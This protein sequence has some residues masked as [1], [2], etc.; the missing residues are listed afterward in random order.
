MSSLT[1]RQLGPP[2]II[3]NPRFKH[4][5]YKAKYVIKVD[6]DCE[7]YEEQLLKMIDANVAEAVAN[8]ESDGDVVYK[9]SAAITSNQL[10]DGIYT[11]FLSTNDFQSERLLTKFSKVQQSANTPS[12][13]GEPFTLEISTVRG[14]TG[15]TRPIGQSKINSDTGVYEIRNQD[16]ACFLLA[17]LIALTKHICLLH[18]DKARTAHRIAEQTTTAREKYIKPLTSWCEGILRKSKYTIHQIAPLVEG[19]FNAEHPEH[20][21]FQ[22]VVFASRNFNNEWLY[23]LEKSVHARTILPIYYNNDHYDTIWYPTKFFNSKYLCYTCHTTYNDKLQHR[24]SCTQKCTLC[25][26]TGIDYPCPFEDVHYCANCFTVFPNSDCYN[27]HL[28]RA[29]Y[30]FKTCQTCEKRYNTRE[31]HT[32]GSSYCYICHGHHPSSTSCFVQSLKPPNE[33]PTYK[34]FVYDFETTQNTGVNGGQKFKHIVN[35][36]AVK[37]MC[38]HCM[39]L[40]IYAIENA[41]PCCPCEL[42]Y[43]SVPED[44]NCLPLQEFW[45]YLRVNTPPGTTNVAVGHYAGRFDIHLLMEEIIAEN[46]RHDIKITSVGNKIYSMSINGGGAFGTIKFIDSYNHIPVSLE[47]MVETLGLTGVV[48]TKGMFPHMLNQEQF[49]NFDEEYLPPKTYYMDEFM[50]PQKRENFLKWYNENK[51]THFNFKQQLRDYC[52][53]DVMILVHALVMF[54]QQTREATGSPTD[55]ILYYTSTLASACMRDFRMTCMPPKSIALVPEHGL[56]RYVNQSKIALKMLR[57]LQHIN[58]YILEYRDSPGGEKRIEVIQDQK[59]HFYFVDG[60]V[61]RSPHKSLIIEI[62]GCY[63]HGCPQCFKNQ[64]TILPQG[65]RREEVFLNTMK[66]QKALEDAGYE[67]QYFWECDIKKMLQEN[68]DMRNFFNDELNNPGPLV[69]RDAFMGGR[70]GP[71][72]LYARSDT[73]TQITYT[74]IQSLYPYVLAK[75][76]MPFGIPERITGT[77]VVHWDS[78]GYVKDEGVYKVLIIP[79]TNLRFPVVP[80]KINEQLMFVL[81]IACAKRHCKTNFPVNID[82]E[83]TPEERQF[84]TTIASVELRLALEKGYIVKRF[85]EL[86]KCTMNMEIFKAYVMKNLK[87]KL[88]ASGPPP[89]CNTEQEKEEYCKEI[90]N[91]Y[92]FTIDKKNWVKNPGLRAIAK[93]RLNSLWGKFGQRTN[94]ARVEI[95]REPSDFHRIL[96]DFGNQI[97][98]LIVVNDTVAYLTIKRKEGYDELYDYSNILL[99]IFTTSCARVHLYKYMDQ[100]QGSS[101]LL[102]TD[103]DSCI[104]QHPR[105]HLPF[106]IDYFLGEMELE[107]GGEEILEYICGGAKQYGLALQNLRTKQVSFE[108]K[109]RGITL[110]HNVRKVLNYELLKKMVFS[111]NSTA[112]LTTSNRIL[113]FIVGGVY[114]VPMTKKYKPVFSK[115]F[116]SNDDLTILPYGYKP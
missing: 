87:L 42:K 61:D 46:D 73:K 21:P 93:L 83:H 69:L 25:G 66:R 75:Y 98:R 103:T 12:L 109:L 111:L 65:R 52:I 92:G 44:E 74:D 72:K 106:K 102:Y 1:F 59:Q 53:N 8:A 105:G 10:T 57:Y 19:Y 20:A 26:R 101:T 30:T 33:E 80:I 45:K 16:S 110:S 63:F 56:G 95:C 96:R 70:T 77:G 6:A 2:E 112:V 79:P 88:E 116:V 100:C 47:K 9:I 29:C 81:C 27:H 4:A 76:P 71:Y 108:L 67:V 36:A 78:P 89:H 107:H 51:Q 91:R 22:I 114:T 115:G 24:S 113:P 37:I 39:T 43:W 11:G 41:C 7:D 50:L 31:A 49:Y 23:P 54:R 85:Y 60:F 62:Y 40:G 17:S 55:D 14:P 82:C 99:P 97:S 86:Y 90:E 18:R 94:L 68:E 38:N 64:H 84:V 35:F 15:G 3:N 104:I 58:G 34:M 32:C 5:T 28:K 48:D 13:L